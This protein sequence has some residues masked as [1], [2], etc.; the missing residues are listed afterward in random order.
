LIDGVCESK[1]LLKVVLTSAQQEGEDSG[2]KLAAGSTEM[3]K[4]QGCFWEH[5]QLRKTELGRNSDSL[6]D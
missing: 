2:Q 6:E 1:G 5:T 3:D 4:L